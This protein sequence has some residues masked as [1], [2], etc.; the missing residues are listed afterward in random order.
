[1]ALI[2]FAFGAALVLLVWQKGRRALSPKTQVV[3]V[4]LAAGLFLGPTWIA[5]EKTAAPAWTIYIMGKDLA[6]PEYA[7]MAGTFALS[8]I[9]GQFLIR[10]GPSPPQAD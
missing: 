6:G 3:M 7:S 1:M 9:L 10:K 8:M 2:A 4:S 5:D